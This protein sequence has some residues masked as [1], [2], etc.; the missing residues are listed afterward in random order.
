MSKYPEYDPV[1]DDEAMDQGEHNT[2][3]GD[4]PTILQQIMQQDPLPTMTG[5]QSPWMGLELDPFDP[6]EGLPVL[7]PAGRGMSRYFPPKS[8]RAGNTMHAASAGHAGE[9]PSTIVKDSEI[10]QNSDVFRLGEICEIMEREAGEVATKNRSQK[11]KLLV[12]S[13]THADDSVMS[14]AQ[15]SVV[16][17]NIS[18]DVAETGENDMVWSSESDGDKSASRN[19][20]KGHGARPRLTSYGQSISVG[21]GRGFSV[22]NVDV[23][24]PPPPFPVK[25]LPPKTVTRSKNIA[26][27]TWRSKGVSKHTQTDYTQTYAQEYNTRLKCSKCRECVWYVNVSKEACTTS[28]E[29]SMGAGANAPP[30]SGHYSHPARAPGVQPSG[31]VD[32]TS[33]TMELV[34]SYTSSPP[35]AHT[36]QHFTLRR[37]AELTHRERLLR[38]AENTVQQRRQTAR[39]EEGVESILNLTTPRHPPQ[40]RRDDKR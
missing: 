40:R 17:Q 1:S 7:N 37:M 27:Q 5:P 9:L 18:S 19:V 8:P 35:Q 13:I 21:I 14:P 29:Q 34:T 32:L 16:Q 24:K 10:D 22:K 11:D 28:H 3:G 12:A 2:S 23:S 33:T 38:R 39:F 4:T 6:D 30:P 15:G 31:V 25:P 26:C 36:I 20:D